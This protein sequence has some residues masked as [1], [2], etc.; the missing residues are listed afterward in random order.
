MLTQEGP[1]VLEFN[2]RF[3]D[4]EVQAVLPRLRT[5]LASLCAEAAAGGLH[6]EPE[7]DDGAAVTVAC[8]SKGYP[9]SPAL[10]DVI[11][12]VEAAAAVPDV[13]LHWAGVDRNAEGRLVT[14]GGRVVWVSARGPDLPTARSRAYEGVSR[15]SFPGMHYRKDIAA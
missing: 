2:V 12:G 10:G 3:G 11:E 15:I 8:A 9:S 7:F 6:T 5:D 1:R 14:A 4:P 13:S